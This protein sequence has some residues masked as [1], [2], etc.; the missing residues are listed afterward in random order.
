MKE[1]TRGRPRLDDRVALR[2]TVSVSL[3][4]PVHDR[5]IELAN[6]YGMS[7]SELARSMIL[8]RQSQTTA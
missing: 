2:S 7:V 1:G 8:S 4:T 6:K 3:P 5:L